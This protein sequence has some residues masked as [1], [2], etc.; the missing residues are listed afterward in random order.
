MLLCSEKIHNK[1]RKSAKGM[2]VSLDQL[3]S[4]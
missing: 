4:V 3:S 2:A 1:Q